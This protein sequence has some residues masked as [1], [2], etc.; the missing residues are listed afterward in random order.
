[1]PQCGADDVPTVVR[2]P[3]YRPRHHSDVAVYASPGSGQGATET[4]NHSL[5]LKSTTIVKRRQTTTVYSWRARGVVSPNAS[6]PTSHHPPGSHND[7]LTR[8]NTAPAEV[9]ETTRLQVAVLR[10]VPYDARDR[11]RHSRCRLPRVSLRASQV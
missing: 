2:E 10:T 4:R 3:G 5:R 7:Q 1:V 9:S 11:T 6:S 8:Q